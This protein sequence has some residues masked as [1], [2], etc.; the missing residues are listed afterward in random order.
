MKVNNRNI[1]YALTAEG[2]EE[3]NRRSW[4][5]FKRTIKNVVV[6]RDAISEVIR[7]AMS[8]GYKGIALVGES[9][10]AF[11]VEHECYKQNAPYRAVKKDYRE[12]EADWFLMLAEIQQHEQAEQLKAPTEE[13]KN[14]FSL[15]RLVIQQ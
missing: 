14:S 8:D 5:Y 1:R 11:I 15:N 2:M 9:D 4:N 6:Y 13:E 7:Q 12:T 10:F 3:L